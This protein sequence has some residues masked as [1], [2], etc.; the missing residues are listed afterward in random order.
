M[1]SDYW[2]QIAEPFKDADL[3]WRV[4]ECGRGE[5]G[6]W[7]KLAAYVDSRAVMKRLDAVCGPQNWK[8][9][10]KNIDTPE[11]V[12]IICR[13]SIWDSEREQWITKEDGA[14]FNR[15]IET[16]K[17]GISDSFKRA[18]NKF[19]M[20]RH[21]YAIGDIWAE[22]I[23]EGRP[24]K[25]SKCVSIY[26][27]RKLGDGHYWC[28]APVLDGKT[29][30]PD[31]KMRQKIGIVNIVIKLEDRAFDNE[32]DRDDARH[33]LL[34]GKLPG[35]ATFEQLE[36]YRNSLLRKI[37]MSLEAEVYPVEKA[38]NA[39]RSKYLGDTD[40][41]KASAEKM[42]AYCKHMGDK[43]KPNILDAYKNPPAEEVESWKS[44]DSRQ[45]LGKLLNANCERMGSLDLEFR[46]SMDELGLW[47][48]KMMSSALTRENLEIVMASSEMF[49]ANNCEVSDG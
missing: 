41:Y 20:G 18:A 30:T 34:E 45:E 11:G 32:T 4:M 26:S 19:G 15:G 24:P 2:E 7:A 47:D 36:R 38:W 3:D 48:Q 21:L 42:M 6:P 46:A 33:D 49:L 27:K 35:D 13:L 44:I 8:D 23:Q 43:N 31:S 5:K 16:A 10:Y 37:A 40:M 9:E 28:L 12:G 1:S 17:S 39:A 29:P 22:K 25:G 14:G